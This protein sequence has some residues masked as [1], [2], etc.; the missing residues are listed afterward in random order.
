MQSETNT[1]AALK[2]FELD[3]QFHSSIIHASANT[4]LIETHT[5]YNRRLFRARF[6]SSRMRLKRAQT[7]SQHQQITDALMARDKERT[8]AEL[9]GHVR[10]AVENIKFA[11]EIDQNSTQINEEDKL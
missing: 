3:M 11:F 4:P 2:F 1:E 6:V 9:R 5:Q 10:S 8:S 7:L